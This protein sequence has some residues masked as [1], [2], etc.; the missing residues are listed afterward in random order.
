MIICD[1]KILQREISICAILGQ[2]TF[3]RKNFVDI[4]CG[5]GELRCKLIEYE[6]KV[7]KPNHLIKSIRSRLT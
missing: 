2:I 6:N 3:V 7:M 4:A 5:Q 1:S